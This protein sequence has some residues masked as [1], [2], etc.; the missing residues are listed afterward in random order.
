[1]YPEVHISSDS[2]KLFE[3]PR[4]AN[5]APAFEM[6]LNNGNL[7]E[8]QK[9]PLFIP[10]LVKALEELEEKQAW[11]RPVLSAPPHETKLTAWEKLEEM[12]GIR[13]PHA[14][15]KTSPQTPRQECIGTQPG[16][17]LPPTLSINARHDGCCALPCD[18]Q[19]L[20]FADKHVPVST[21]LKVAR[22]A[23]R[24]DIEPLFARRA[25]SGVTHI[26]PVEMPWFHPLGPP[27]DAYDIRGVCY[28]FQVS[29]DADRWRY[30]MRI[31]PILRDDLATAFTL[32]EELEDICGGRFEIVPNSSKTPAF[33]E[34]SSESL[35]G[36]YESTVLDVSA[37]NHS[38]E[39]ILDVARD[40]SD[41]SGSHILLSDYRD[42]GQKHRAPPTIFADQVDQHVG[43][44][45]ECIKTFLHTQ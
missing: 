13:K 18:K 20:V 36:S 41:W 9:H 7:P 37:S 2:L 10:A 19:V 12:S 14:S 38:P 44:Y 1:M 6:R 26:F 27:S 24:R 30:H 39:Q 11:E 25:A 8:D 42:P 21:W 32:A 5:L 4:E 33:E 35:C 34:L 15:S 28:S 29:P 22:S 40:L 17:Y 3:Q 43:Q 45:H 23:A 31:R 16:F